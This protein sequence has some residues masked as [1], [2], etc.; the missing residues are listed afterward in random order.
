MDLH[1]SIKA[2]EKVL[3]LE[4]DVASIFKLTDDLH[5]A[6]ADAL[7]HAE[8]HKYRDAI[9]KK[10]DSLVS[11]EEAATSGNHHPPF[12]FLESIYFIL[13]LCFEF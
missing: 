6:Q 9:A 12:P 8:E 13:L 7:N 3:E 10:L 5:V 11:L 4:T 2:N 1:A